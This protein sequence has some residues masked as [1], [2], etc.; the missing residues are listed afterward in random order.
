METL[1]TEGVYSCKLWGYKLLHAYRRLNF[2]GTL[3][4]AFLKRYSVSVTR[5]KECQEE[6]PFVYLDEDE[7]AEPPYNMS[8]LLG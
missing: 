3:E 8:P 4:D 5:E 7:M 6:I 2:V 1:G